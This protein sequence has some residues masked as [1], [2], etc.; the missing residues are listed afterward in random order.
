[1]QNS[2]IS[3]VPNIEPLGRASD[4]AYEFA[5]ATR[6]NALFGRFSLQECNIFSDYM[7][8]FGVPRD[9]PILRQRRAGDFLIIV[10]TGCVDLIRT[11]TLGNQVARE[12]IGPG[13]M[14]GEMSLVDGS[15]YESSCIA[16]EPT[17]FAVLTRQ[18]L[19]AVVHEHPRVGNKFLSLLIQQL[20]HRLRAF[21]GSGDNMGM[22]GAHS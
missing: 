20:T 4:Y 22:I 2:S 15:D 14:A 8:C 5:E 10:L 7:K 19:D 1:M 12:R 17:D 11:D 16:A 9:T 13:G 3:L 21:T 6:C 18:S